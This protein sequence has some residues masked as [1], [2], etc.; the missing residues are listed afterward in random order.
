M[1]PFKEQPFFVYE[2]L[3]SS[4][5]SFRL[6]K[7]MPGSDDAPVRCELINGSVSAQKD[8]FVALSYTWGSA[9]EPRW[10]RL[11]GLA[12]H[13]Q[14]NLLDALK[15]IRAADEEILIWIDAICIN[16]RDVMEKNHQVS[17]MGDIYRNAKAVFAWL[18][19][20]ADDSDAY[21]DYLDKFSEG[22]TEDMK[23]AANRAV[24]FLNRRP[25][26]RRAWIKQE[27]ILAK[28]IKVY[29]GS[30]Y[31]PSGEL[32]FWVAS[33]STID[34]AEGFDD[35]IPSIYTHRTAMSEGKRETLEELLRRY[36]RTES[37]DPRDRVFA[38]FSMASDCNS[39][40]SG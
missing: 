36:N 21:F 10:I 20:A 25:Y 32:F 12:F 2:S 29:C 1:S 8:R 11:N 23:D 31:S 18:G 7:L 19:P 24:K 4:R 14:Q 17:M 27:L 15:V 39:L 38:L 16:Q 3:G 9:A 30:R 37:S 34:E 40:D 22:A 13:V 5:D 28:E 6:C 35:Y 26:W 33:L